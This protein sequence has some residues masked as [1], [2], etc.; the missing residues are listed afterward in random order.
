VKNVIV[1][2][3]VGGLVLFVWGFLFWGLSS[4]PY[5]A[6]SQ[7]VPDDATAGQALMQYFPQSG[8]YYIPGP[9]NP[10][11]QLKALH[12]AGPVAFVF[13]NREGKAK[14]P[15]SMLLTGYVHCVELALLVALGL[16]A[17][18]NA[19]PAY[20]QRVRLVVMFGLASSL[21]GPIA[22]IIWW[23]YPPGW[24]W[25][26]A[27]EQFVSWLLLAFVLPKFVRAQAA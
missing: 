5:S 10:L 15:P 19:L 17:L 14:K 24:Q 12:E 7:A 20:G 6:L 2:S 13:F 1:G 21:W 18:G 4:L 22:L 23:Y 8:A 27:F 25:W 16:R 3:L 9:H 26:I 11:D